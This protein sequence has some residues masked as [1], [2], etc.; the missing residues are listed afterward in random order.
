MKSLI[1]VMIAFLCLGLTVVHAEKPLPESIPV[2]A[3]QDLDYAMYRKAK[4]LQKLVEKYDKIINDELKAS[5]KD[6]TELIE[7]LEKQYSLQL[8]PKE[9]NGPHDEVDPDTGKVTR[10]KVSK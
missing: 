10:H 2:K 1:S 7:R 6:E 3:A 5:T 9:P 8:Y 4:K